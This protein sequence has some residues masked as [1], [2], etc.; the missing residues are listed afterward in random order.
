L[1]LLLQIA[2]HTD[3]LDQATVDLNLGPLQEPSAVPFAFSTIG[4]PILGAVVLVLLIVVATLAIRKYNHNRYRREALAEL[5]QVVRGEIDFVHSMVL[6]KRTAIHAFGRDKV[7]KLTGTDWFK[8]LD[9]HAR[10][11]QFLSIQSEVEGLIYKSETPDQTTR[12]KIVV[13]V[14]NWINTHGAA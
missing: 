9:G 6:V 2:S 10:Q 3:S 8:F 11:V 1:I 12:D 5:Q 14:K 4:W 13:N 7:G